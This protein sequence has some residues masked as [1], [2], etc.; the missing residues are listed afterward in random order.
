MK[1]IDMTDKLRNLG[2]KNMIVRF[3]KFMRS[4]WFID[5]DTVLSAKSWDI[6]LLSCGAVIHAVD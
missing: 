1:V 2:E 3:G 5:R 4:Y 6:S